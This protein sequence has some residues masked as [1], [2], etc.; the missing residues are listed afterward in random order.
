MASLPR[1]SLSH[2]LALLALPCVLTCAGDPVA[3][4]SVAAVVITSPAEPLAIRTLGRSV[5]FTA[6]AR[7]AD[8]HVLAAQPIA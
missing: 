6:E 3:T 4:V 2:L 5:R 8:G 1:V 7:D